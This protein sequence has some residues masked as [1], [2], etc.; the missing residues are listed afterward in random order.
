MGADRL[1]AVGLVAAVLLA[2]WLG[3]R[4]R[5]GRY[6]RRPATDLVRDGRPLVLAFVTAD[7]V[8]CRTV[9][10]PALEELRRRF[11]HHL[12]VREVDATADVALARRFGILTVPST[13]LI[14]SGG[15]VVAIN[16]GAVGWE[17]LAAQLGL[18]G[19]GR[20][21]RMPVRTAR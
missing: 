19:G 17:R 5:V 2:A 11:P 15:R 21:A 3:L 7:C 14:S 18:N 10:K 6:R 20:H 16:H 9:Q 13:V 1:L 4:W 12:D 8:P